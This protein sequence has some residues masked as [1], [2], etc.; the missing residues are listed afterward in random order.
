MPGYHS[1][2]EK[3]P[4]IF[5]RLKREELQLFRT[6]KQKNTLL[7]TGSKREDR[8]P[9]FMVCEGDQVWVEVMDL[10]IT[11]LYDQIGRLEL[12][13]WKEAAG[14][15][16]KS[17]ESVTNASFVLDSRE[18]PKL[19]V[20]NLRSSIQAEED[21]VSGFSIRFNYEVPNRST[22]NRY[23]LDLDQAC[24]SE[25]SPIE[26]MKLVTGPVAKE[27]GRYELLSRMGQVELF[28]P[29]YALCNSGSYSPPIRLHINGDLD[30]NEYLLFS[31]E[32]DIKRNAFDLDDL[33]FGQFKF[34]QE[35]N[36][37]QSGI[38]LS[39][40]YRLPE[41]YIRDHP[42]AIFQI[43][44][45]LRA[46][47]QS[48]TVQKT[49][50][51]DRLAPEEALY[52]RNI[53]G[54]N[55]KGTLLL[56][57]PYTRLKPGKR[58]TT[59]G[60]ELECVMLEGETIRTLG[61]YGVEQELNLPELQGLSI[62][63]REASVRK[64]ALS[65]ETPNL[66]WLLWVGQEVIYVAPVQRGDFSPEWEP[67]HKAR[68]SVVDTDQLRISLV[69]DKENGQFMELGTWSGKLSD[70]PLAGEEK[71]VSLAGG[72]KMLIV[73]EPYQ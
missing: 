8:S 21:G 41:D 54:R 36:Q 2:K 1:P 17:F 55:P 38:M 48:L 69:Q 14:K 39:C 13:P 15:I 26:F 50:I 52:V 70:L 64:S 27:Y 68:T 51:A 66:R 73:R 23:Y 62:R 72:A 33:E 59:C 47:N 16:E 63:V 28:L 46:D 44:A 18:P 37:G 6:P 11:S 31:R 10:D 43:N 34:G 4:E 5:W 24:D 71:K 45:D 29:Y 49:Q 53:N 19:T 3:K 9:W 56:F 25:D 57:I 67:Y 7:Y 35:E 30:G 12:D 22:E 58:A 20:T 42:D 61:T 40:D 60:V 32:L 65:K